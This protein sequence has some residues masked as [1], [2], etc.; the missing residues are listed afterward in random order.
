MKGSD[1][2]ILNGMGILSQYQRLGGNALLY[3][4]L[5]KTV[6]ERSFRTGRARSDFRAHR[7]D[8]ARYPD[9]G[10]PGVQGA[11]HLRKGLLSRREPQGRRCA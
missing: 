8:A 3:S 9:P 10:R 5:T 2:L 7:A 1:A 4:E 11:P 6:A